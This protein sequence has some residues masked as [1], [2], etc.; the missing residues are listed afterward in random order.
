MMAFGTLKVLEYSIMTSATEMIYMPMDHD[1]RYL[2]KE[3]VR[4]FGHKMGRTVAVFVLSAA[5][6]HFNPSIGMQSSWAG[7]ITLLWIVI[8]SYLSTHLAH[9]NQVIEKVA[10]PLPVISDTTTPTTCHDTKE[11]AGIELENTSD[12]GTTTHENTPNTVYTVSPNSVSELYNSYVGDYTR[13]KRSHSNLGRIL[14]ITPSFSSLSVLDNKCSSDDHISD[15]GD[16]EDDDYADYIDL[17]THDDDEIQDFD[18]KNIADY[19]NRREITRKNQSEIIRGEKGG[20]SS[21]NEDT[22]NFHTNEISKRR[23]C[24]DSSSKEKPVGSPKNGSFFSRIS[25]FLH[26]G[27]ERPLMFRVGSTA[28]TMNNLVYENMLRSRSDS[29][30]K[31]KKV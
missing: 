5:N 14:T 17:D 25:Q 24:K 4:F 13:Y 26:T 29:R 11:M 20:G 16:Q 15:Q 23:G 21:F 9:R 30:D 2:G 19:E 28:M 31:D 27:N 3:L 18:H 22:N 12:D 1:H 6:A 7:S 8:M 10:P